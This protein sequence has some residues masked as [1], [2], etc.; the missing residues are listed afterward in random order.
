M[1]GPGTDEHLFEFDDEENDEPESD[2]SED[3]GWDAED[4]LDFE[5][6]QPGS[7]HRDY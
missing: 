2:E 6:D 1:N 7:N 4:E 3:F 5:R